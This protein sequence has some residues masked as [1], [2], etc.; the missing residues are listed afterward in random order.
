MPVIIRKFPS[1]FCHKPSPP[2]IH[3]ILWCSEMERN[4]YSALMGNTEFVIHFNVMFSVHRGLKHLVPGVSRCF[5]V[6]SALPTLGQVLLFQ[7]LLETCHCWEQ[8]GV[9][10][11]GMWGLSSI[12][13]L[14]CVLQHWHPCPEGWMEREWLKAGKIPLHLTV[15]LLFWWF[16]YCFLFWLDFHH[17]SARY[18]I[19]TVE[20][21]LWIHCWCL[22]AF[23]HQG[24]GNYPWVYL[25]SEKGFFRWHL[26]QPVLGSS[27]SL[28]SQWERITL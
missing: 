4:A 22:H 5:S 12:R 8:G 10:G 15:L 20:L 11:A 16:R 1:S 17:S 23:V 27:L 25:F 28:L 21:P 7:L 18:L 13:W 2:Y 24:G 6:C 19:C 26:E 3:H 9:L 14:C